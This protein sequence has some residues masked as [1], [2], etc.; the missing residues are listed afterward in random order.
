MVGRGVLRATSE[1]LAPPRLMLLLGGLGTPRSPGEGTAP[2]ALSG[3]CGM[4]RDGVIGDDPDRPPNAPF[5]PPAAPVEPWKPAGADIFET[6]GRIP[7]RAGG[8]DAD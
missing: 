8:I 1:L 7:E 4:I 2:D 6:T 5:P 3:P